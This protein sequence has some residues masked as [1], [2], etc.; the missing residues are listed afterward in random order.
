MGSICGYLARSGRPFQAPYLGVFVGDS[1]RQI[2]GHHG[3]DTTN[4]KLF[5][6]SAGTWVG[7]IVDALLP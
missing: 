3:E 7:S 4:M 1:R 2:T 5:D 6:S